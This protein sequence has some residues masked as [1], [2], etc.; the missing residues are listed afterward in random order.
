VSRPRRTHA[1][2]V[3]MRGQV[4]ARVCRCA[5][6]VCV[7]LVDVESGRRGRSGEGLGWMVVSFRC[8]LIRKTQKSSGTVGPPKDKLLRALSSIVCSCYGS[9]HR[10]WQGGCDGCSSYLNNWYQSQLHCLELEVMPRSRSA[11]P[12]RY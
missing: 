10:R 11:L 5:S 6:D 8:L 12:L 1:R 4:L 2:I 9:L 3:R 7:G